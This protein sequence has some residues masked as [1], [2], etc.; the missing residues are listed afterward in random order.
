MPLA[1]GTFT[2]DVTFTGDSSNGLWDKSASAFV[3]NLTG[4]VTGNVSGSAAT[5]TGAA[6][7]AITSLGTL[8]GLTS[9]GNI[10]IDSDS[11]KLRLGADQD[12]SVFHDGTNGHIDNNTGTLNLDSP[13]A[14]KLF[15]NGSLKYYTD[16][17]GLRGGDD[18]KLK[19]GDSQDLKIYHDGSNGWNYIQSV[20]NNIAIQ[21]KT[22]ENSIT[23]YADDRVE[24]YYDNSKKFETTS[25]G[26]IG[27]GYFYVDGSSGIAYAAPDNSK[28]SLGTGNDLQIYHDGTQSVIEGTAPLYLKGSSVVIYKGGTTEKMLQCNGDGE[29]SLWHDNVKTVATSATGC[30]ITGTVSDSKGDLRNI[31]MNYKTGAYTLLASDAGKHIMS[32]ASVTIPASVMAEGNAVTIVNMHTGDMTITQAS[33]LTMYNTADATTGNRVLA[34]RGMATILFTSSTTAY[35]SGAGLS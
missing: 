33:G 28:V 27:Y 1:G 34:T 26:A 11:T 31:P 24:L 12:F 17:D 4:N 9:T 19:F 30:T 15:H 16:T 6:Q 13:S 32:N 7:S 25:Y 14:I 3:A 5:V 23:C 2:G 35:M 22:G 20:A 18:V 29:T 10:D 21:A 8:T